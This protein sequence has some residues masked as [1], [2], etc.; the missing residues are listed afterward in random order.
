MFMTS[1]EDA[2][3]IMTLKR[4]GLSDRRIARQLGLDR[5]TVKKYTSDPGI[6]FK[7]RQSG[8]KKSKLDPFSE[9]VKVWIDQD[10]LYSSVWVYDRLKPMGYT[11]GYEIVKKFVSGLKAKRTQVAYLR[12]ETEPGMQAQVDWAEFVWSL[13]DGTSRTFYLFAMILGFSRYLYCELVEKCDLT[14][15]LDCHIRAF[16]YFGGVP[17]EILYDRMKNVF[18]R[19][20]AG[21]TEFNRSLTSLAL[22]YGF[23]PLV[24]PAYAP[25]VKGKI[26]RPMEFVREGF[27]RGYG[28]TSLERSNRDLLAW[29]EMK[30][31]RIHGTTHERVCDRFER[32]KPTLGSIPKDAFDTSYQAFRPVHKDCTVHFETNRYMVPHTLVGKNLVLRVKNRVVRIYDDSSHIVTYMIPEQKGQFVFEQRFIDALKNDREMNRIK[33]GRGIRCRKGRAVTISPSVPAWAMDVETRSLNVYDRVQQNS[34][35]SREGVAA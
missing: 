31:H 33:Y 28:F 23:K 26:E 7:P 9:N 13:P 5:R 1:K 27:W 20:L 34:P 6:A 14:T 24:A 30:S 16:E 18:I 25:W 12:F 8:P 21:K 35:A 2:L 17:D 15:F 19:K 10:P 22:H 11:G 32:E 3:D 4:K 29:L